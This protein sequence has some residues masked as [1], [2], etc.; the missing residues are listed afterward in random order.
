MTGKPGLVHTAVSYTRPELTMSVDTTNRWVHTRH[1]HLTAPRLCR[2]KLH[3][4]RTTTVEKA[5]A[6]T[7]GWS[8]GSLGFLTDGSVD[9][10]SHIFTFVQ[11]G[12]VGGYE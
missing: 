10:A 12:R 6:G 5:D 4:V 3:G 11:L 8:L 9:D 2:M 7:L 1:V